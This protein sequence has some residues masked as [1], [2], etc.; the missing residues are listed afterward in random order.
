LG[1]AFA[2]NCITSFE[3]LMVLLGVNL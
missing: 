3:M 1:S 2:E